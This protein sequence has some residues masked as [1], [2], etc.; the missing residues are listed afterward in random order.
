[1]LHSQEKNK[2]KLVL[3]YVVSVVVDELSE[4]R[5]IRKKCTIL[6]VHK[7]QVSK[8]IISER[9]FCSLK[10]YSERWILASC[11][12]LMSDVLALNLCTVKIFATSFGKLVD[13]SISI[14][15]RQ[16]F[17][18]TSVLL[19]KIKFIVELCKS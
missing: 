2:N 6:F 7:K 12:T 3:E 1:M 11:V 4:H 5:F 15:M 19:Q 16:Y 10:K 8:S 13:T 9:F 14:F 18:T 17:S